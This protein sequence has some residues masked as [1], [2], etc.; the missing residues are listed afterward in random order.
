MSPHQPLDPELRLEVEKL[1]LQNKER[2][3][4]QI[5]ETHD[6]WVSGGKTLLIRSLRLIK[7]GLGGAYEEKENC[8][9]YLLCS[10][11]SS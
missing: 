10:L 6:L 9:L 11:A 1:I 8:P 2:G 3:M 7:V 5:V 4:T